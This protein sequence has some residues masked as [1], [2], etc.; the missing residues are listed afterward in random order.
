MP[1]R[2]S[3]IGISPSGF[4]SY[5][6]FYEYII[7]RDK[8]SVETINR[9]SKLSIEILSESYNKNKLKSRFTFEQRYGGLDK[10]IIIYLLQYIIENQ[11]YI[12]KDIA[13]FISVGD[14]MTYSTLNLDMG[15]NQEEKDFFEKTILDNLY[16]LF[17]FKILVK[18]WSNNIEFVVAAMHEDDLFE[19]LISYELK[20]VII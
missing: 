18:K 4:E 3:L 19:E 9:L 12:E 14:I 20:T 16:Y 5:C 7:N 17:E 8:N 10:H 13:R 15:R 2:T 6:F 11:A 1:F